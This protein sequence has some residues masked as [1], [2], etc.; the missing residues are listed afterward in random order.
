MKKKKRIEK[1]EIEFGFRYINYYLIPEDFN[2][3]NIYSYLSQNNY[4]NIDDV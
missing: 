4:S 1:K 2:H 3:F